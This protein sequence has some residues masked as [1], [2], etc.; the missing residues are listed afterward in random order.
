MRCGLS[1][2]SRVALATRSPGERTAIWSSTGVA[3]DHVYAAPKPRRRSRVLP[4]E[5]FERPVDGKRWHPAGVGCVGIGEPRIPAA[6]EVRAIVQAVASGHLP[7]GEVERP[8]RW[9]GELPVDDA[10]DRP[11]VDQEVLGQPVAVGER[12]PERRTG[13]QLSTEEVS[14]ALDDR[15][16]RGTERLARDAHRSGD[17]ALVRRLELVPDPSVR[18]DAVHP[19]EELTAVHDQ[20]RESRRGQLA[21]E[22]VERATRHELQDGERQQLAVVIHLPD[23][24]DIGRRHADTTRLRHDVLLV[25]EPRYLLTRA[26]DDHGHVVANL[27]AVRLVNAATGEAEEPPDLAAA[28]GPHHRVDDRTGRR[29]HQVPSRQPACERQPTLL[30]P[31]L[32]TVLVAPCSVSWR[33]AICRFS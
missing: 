5:H 27:Y 21:S 26:P 4:T 2:R 1:S 24:E 20:P 19:C 16:R 22:L 9:A 11:V 3:G 14:T 23:A 6:Q 7:A 17:E 10:D 30:R 15:G 32:V 18:D 25:S 28:D 29:R 12:E 31:A 13:H 8:R 33:D